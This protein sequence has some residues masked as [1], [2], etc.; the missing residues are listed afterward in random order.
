MQLASAGF[1][2]EP[3]ASAPDQVQ[4]FMCH[5]HF[6]GWDEN[7]DPV[8]EHL[9]LAPGCAWALQMGVEKEIEAGAEVAEHPISERMIEAR[10]D[11]FGDHWPHE[12]KR[13]W[14]CRVQ[15]VNGLEWI[16]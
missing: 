15:K 5:N 6:D 14:V 9:A 12:K 2:F 7:D 10:I 8:Q 13:G 3:T 4:C 1:F 11:T 16:G